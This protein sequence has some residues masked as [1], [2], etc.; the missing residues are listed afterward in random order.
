[1]APRADLVERATPLLPPG[2]VIRQ[3]FIAQS[4]PNFGYFIITY[5][6]GLTMF[7]NKYRCV[8]VTDDALYVLESTKLSGGADP[9]SLVGTVPRSTRLGPTSGHWTEIDLL[10]ERHWV[11]QRFYEQLAE[12]DRERPTA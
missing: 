5:L 12:A 4:A 8:A 1:M 7:R 11:H 10:G 2:S 6:T 9:R 3:A